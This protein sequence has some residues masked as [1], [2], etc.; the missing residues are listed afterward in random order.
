MITSIHGLPGV[1]KNVYATYLALK[2]YKKTN[3]L[4]SRFSR[5]IHHLPERINITFFIK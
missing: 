2:H 4:I 5:R 1:G 3:S